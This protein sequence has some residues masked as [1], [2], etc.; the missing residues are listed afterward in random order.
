MLLAGDNTAKP[1]PFGRL[2][3][4]EQGT[5]GWLGL[6]NCGRAGKRARP[7]QKQKGYRRLP[8]DGRSKFAHRVLAA[9]TLPDPL[10]VDARAGFR[11]SVREN[12]RRSQSPP[13]QPFG[14]TFPL[15]PPGM[16][17][18]TGTDDSVLPGFQVKGQ[19]D[20]PSFEY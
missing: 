9:D 10:L 4:F 15:K 8:V 14:T 3:N 5:K 20:L 19:R 18:G 16:P 7:A 11:F 1:K 17:P 2:D 6:K 12:Q 13:Q